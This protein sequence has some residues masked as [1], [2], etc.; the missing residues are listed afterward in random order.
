[1]ADYAKQAKAQN[2]NIVSKFESSLEELLAVLGKSDVNVMAPGTA[3]NIYKSSGALQ[4]TQVAEGA[5]ITASTHKMELKKT[6]E[7]TYSKYRK[8]TGIETIGKLGYDIAVLGSNEA[9]LKDVQ[10][11][12]RASI[13]TGIKT[14]TGTV[15]SAAGSTFQQQV[16]AAWGALS[17]KFE[18]EAA[19]PVF[20]ANPTDVAGYLGTANVT[21]QTAFGMSYLKNF[22]GL[23][24]LLIDSNVAAGTVIATACENIDVVS[25]DISAIPEMDMTT[26]RGGVIA[27]HNG[28]RYAN[29]GIETVMYCGLS[30][31]PV[32]LDRVI[33][34]TVAAATTGGGTD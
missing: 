10:K 32:F 30:V 1:M 11:A 27:V 14:G 25:A 12:V 16:A 28:A 33:K 18:D 13:Y 19:T 15:E 34:S 3:M 23:G 21:T 2:V 26:D 20:F 9:M 31:F 7:L 4:S 22:M 6:V 29:A 24:N 17:A 5:E 8:V